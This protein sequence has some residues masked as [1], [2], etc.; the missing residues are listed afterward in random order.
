MNAQATETSLTLGSGRQLHLLEPDA[1]GLPES[2]YS[3]FEARGRFTGERLF[4]RNPQLYGAIVKLL[5]RAIP[6]REI[7]DI[8]EVSVNTV[9]GVCMREGVPIETLRERIGKLGMDVAALT[10]E[11]VRDLLADPDARR[12]FSIKDLMIAHGI[13]SQNAQL[14]L[15]GATVRIGMEGPPPTPGH[16][17]YLRFM[18]R[19]TKNVTPTGSGGETP[20][21][22][23]LT[24]SAPVI[25]LPV[26]AA[27]A[28]P[29]SQPE[30]AVS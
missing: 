11:A 7:A 5:A 16:E 30:K 22:R 10:I 13:A 28:T 25:D 20:A 26:E 1:V 18:E 21:Q 12:R 15:G 2:A 24:D 27:Q 19:V 9:C 6:Y 14:F 8:C 29:D 3:D 23:A 4:L 17:D